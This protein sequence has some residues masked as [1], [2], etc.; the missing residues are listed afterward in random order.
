MLTALVRI[1]RTSER[2]VRRVVAGDDVAGHLRR[3]L[4]AWPS[5]VR[6][7]PAIVEGADALVLEA[8]SWVGDGSAALDVPSTVQ[9]FSVPQSR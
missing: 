3:D 7:G 9:M 4:G 6:L 1:D 2:H 5:L 8:A